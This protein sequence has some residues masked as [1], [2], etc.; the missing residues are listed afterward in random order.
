MFP[1]SD[2]FFKRQRLIDAVAGMLGADGP[3]NGALADCDLDAWIA[4]GAAKHDFVATGHRLEV[5]GL[6][7]DCRP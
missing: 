5:T 3:V 6:C 1:M 4:A 2:D 7:A